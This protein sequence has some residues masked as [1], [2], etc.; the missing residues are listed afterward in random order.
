MANDSILEYLKTCETKIIKPENGE[1]LAII[2]RGDDLDSG[3]LNELSQAFKEVLGNVN[4]RVPII[5]LPTDHDIDFITLKEV[6][7]KT[8]GLS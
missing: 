7:E 2:V 3:I 8:N 6:L 4:R 5:G 1:P